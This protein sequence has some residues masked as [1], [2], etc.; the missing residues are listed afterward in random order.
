MPPRPAP[1]AREAKLT[2]AQGRQ[3]GTWALHPDKARNRELERMATQL[4]QSGPRDEER[5]V[6]SDSQLRTAA[7][8][9]GVGRIDSLDNLAL[10]MPVRSRRPGRRHLRLASGP[11]TVVDA[12]LPPVVSPP[13]APMGFRLVKREAV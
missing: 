4:L 8:R 10:D 5:P 11:P 3:L 1:V 6:L 9:E 7:R 2:P 12:E 13:P